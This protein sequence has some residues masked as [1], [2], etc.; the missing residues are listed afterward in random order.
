[1][2]RGEFSTA[3]E[4]KSLIPFITFAIRHALATPVAIVAGCV[5]WTVAYLLLLLWAVI[6]GHGLG[7]P[8][9]YPAGIVAVVAGGVLIGWGIFAPACAAGALFCGFSGFTRFAAIPVVFAV[10][11][12]FSYLIYWVF[13]EW[14][15]TSPIPSFG[16][17]IGNYAMFLSVPLGGYWWVT[18]GPGAIFESFRRWRAK[19]SLSQTP[20][21]AR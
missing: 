4:M 7:G 15:T 9:A 14:G 8:L 11:F 17:I 19:R 18:E 21:K 6:F 2:K 13:I 20:G 5:L 3:P 10:G 16:I 12:L 1:M